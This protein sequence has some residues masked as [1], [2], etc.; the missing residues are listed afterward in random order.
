MDI[1]AH[2]AD[3]VWTAPPDE[4]VQLRQAYFKSSK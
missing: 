1:D 4:K 3:L 2:R